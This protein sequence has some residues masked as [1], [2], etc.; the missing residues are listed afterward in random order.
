M[1]VSPPVLNSAGLI[2]NRPA[3]LF[4]DEDSQ[5]A[6]V[7]H[8]PRGVR[9]RSEPVNKPINWLLGLDEGQL[10]AS[11]Q[12]RIQPLHQLVEPVSGDIPPVI[13]TLTPR[14]RT[15]RFATSKNAVMTF[16]RGMAKEQGSNIRVNALCPGMGDTNF[17]NIHTQPE[18]RKNVANAS[19]VKR[20][21]TPKDVAKLVAIL[22][23]DQ[24][25]FM[26]GA[27][28]DINGGMLFS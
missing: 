22:A 6:G 21:G 1:S 8:D 14:L 23:S 3:S 20:E 28:V 19:P 12:G 24:S 9:D 15:Y 11:C 25:A 16:S 18:V 7:S 26:I 27:N 17:H 10:E 5:H 13:V 4:S 2:C